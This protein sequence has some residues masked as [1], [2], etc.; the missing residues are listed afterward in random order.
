MAWE[1][2]RYFIE[3]HGPKF[4]SLEIFTNGLLLDET[5]LNWLVEKKVRISVST[6]GTT[7]EHYR[8]I[9][10]ETSLFQVHKVLFPRL[11][12]SGGDFKVCL[13]RMRGNDHET[14]QGV[15]DF[16]GIPLNRMRQ[17]IVRMTGRAQQNLLT[18]RLLRDC[19]LG[20]E[21]F[22]RPIRKSQVIRNVAG[23]SCFGMKVYIASDLR[24]YPC[25]MERRVSYGS[26]EDHTL[27][28][29]ISQSHPT[30]RLTK[31]GIE[32]CRECEFRYACYD[33]RPNNG[34]QDFFAKPWFCRYNPRIGV[35]EHKINSEV[36][37]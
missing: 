10:G 37:L 34:S 26:L 29:I 30:R 18:E 7:R 23:H 33:C 2:T 11:E 24:T 19:Q 9:A 13:M 14:L 20:P 17:D 21:A 35:W 5:K 22:R 3:T 1:E 25:A 31:D 15:A 28:E 4:E 12:A 36:V 27:S 16:Y 32:G 8:A 6:Y